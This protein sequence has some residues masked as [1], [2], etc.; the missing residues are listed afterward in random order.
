MNVPK[1]SVLMTVYNAGAYL[2]A[3]LASITDQSFADW[4]L[5]VV[6]D[7]STD[8]SLSV[9]QD[10]SR[11]DPRIRV[12]PNQQNKGQTP[13]LNQG[14]RLCQGTWIARQDADDLSHPRRLELQLEYLQNHPETVLL[15][16]QGVLI[17]EYG[18]R[19]GLLDVPCDA[20]GILWA[21]SFLN[22]FL[23]TSVI[24]RRDVV[25]AEFGGYDEG[26]RIAQDYDLWMRLAAMCPTANLKARLVS[27]RHLGSSLSKTGSETAFA[28][29]SLISGRESKRVFR[30]SLDTQE[31]IM[32]AAFR[33]GLHAS[34]IPTFHALCR[35][36]EGEFV[37]RHPAEHGGPPSV[38]TAW[39][40]KIAGSVAHESPFLALREVASAFIADPFGVL[41]WAKERVANS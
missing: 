6:D 30:R 23:H 34:E 39:K 40:L 2:E 26:F 35:R 13:C 19:M 4:E 25:V 16:T 37:A 36:L 5:V 38:K 1:V 22:P 20:A 9:L 21:A 33:R 3:S 27:Y 10:W 12:I 29:A 31:E 28:E 15:G 24:F 8:G 17:N 7:A 11:R 18:R 14:L 32:F 41:R